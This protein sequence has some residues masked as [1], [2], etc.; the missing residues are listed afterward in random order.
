MWAKNLMKYYYSKNGFFW[1]RL[2]HIKFLLCFAT[3]FKSLDFFKLFCIV[4]KWNKNSY[5]FTPRFLVCFTVSIWQFKVL[6]SRTKAHFFKRVSLFI[7]DSNQHILCTIVARSNWLGSTKKGYS[8]VLFVR[9]ASEI[10]YEK[11]CKN[12][13]MFDYIRSRKMLHIKASIKVTQVSL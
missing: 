6:Y 13:N 9:L 11:S 1:L 4:A 3:N 8:P 7:E 5:W 10:K 2:L 12:K